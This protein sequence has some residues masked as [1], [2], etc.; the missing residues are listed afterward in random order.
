M[1]CLFC[2]A[3]YVCLPVNQRWWGNWAE[4]LLA[5]EV[6]GAWPS[7]NACRVPMG[8]MPDCIKVI[9][10]STW[11]WKHLRANKQTNKKS[12]LCF[13]RR[14]FEITRAYTVYSQTSLIRTPVI[15]APPSTGQ[16]ICLILCWHCRNCGQYSGCG[17]LQPMYLYCIL[18]YGHPLIPRR[19]DERALT[20]ALYF[21]GPKIS[22]LEHAKWFSEIIFAVSDFLNNTH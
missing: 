13:F 5:R 22:C 7:E 15:R 6:W 3:L 4:P 16:L 18:S 1:Y 21:R 11:V 10:D 19:P 2:D 14:Q 12:V 17:L 9:G 8:F 20:V